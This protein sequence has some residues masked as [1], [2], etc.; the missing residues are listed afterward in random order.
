MHLTS[1]RAPRLHLA[2]T[3][4]RTLGIFYV[5]FC[6]TAGVSYPVLAADNDAT[7][8]AA[9]DSLGGST[10]PPIYDWNVSRQEKPLLSLPAQL[11]DAEGLSL[12][13]PMGTQKFPLLQLL[14]SGNKTNEYVVQLLNSTTGR[15][16]EV[17]LKVFDTTESSVHT[18]SGNLDLTDNRGVM[19]LRTGMGTEYTFVKF[20]DGVKR[21]VRVKA[22]D[23]VL[24]N[25]LY[26][27]D[28]LI[29][30]VVDSTG[31]S[32]R[33]GYDN[34]R[35]T[36]VTQ[37][38]TVNSVGFSKTW[39]VGREREQ[40][41][42]AHAA[43]PLPAV[44]KF[45][46]PIPNNA[47]TPQYTSSMANSDRKLAAIFGSASAV[48]AAN[49]YEPPALASQYPLYRGDLIASDGRLVR[50]H[51]S[52]AMHLYG[53]AEGTGDSALYVPAGFTSHSLQP[54][55]TDA[56]VTFYYPRLGNMTD[57]TLAVFHVANFE[58]VPEG[59]RVRIGNIGGPGGSYSQYK[60]SHIEFYRGNTGLPATTTAREQL[61]ID[62]AK[63]F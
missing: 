5:T 22:A 49:S 1:R 38:W 18:G 4:F 26:G 20:T 21:C 30:G 34:R 9:E 56:A 27:S 31:R 42:L 39:T 10:R 54:G 16:V 46:K 7:R 24:L 52:Y 13:F 50:G 6:V 45:L 53:N 62:P 28:N 3:L 15:S 12:A 32:I 23:G 25:L 35:I 19:T 59:G 55:P 11:S 48:A 61:R 8:P 40:V 63:V 47:I 36:S 2:S 57:V 41:K 51:L 14:K 44:A 37:T 33:F 60:H 17:S 58:I 43:A 29:H